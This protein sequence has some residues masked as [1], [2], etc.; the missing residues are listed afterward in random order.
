MW[1]AQATT[2]LPNLPIPWPS[3]GAG[4]LV[5]LAVWLV[6][7]GRLIPRRIHQDTLDEVKFLR[8]TI[9]TMQVVKVELAQQNTK[10]LTEKDLGVH[11]LQSARAETDGAES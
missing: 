7:T 5:T 3:L 2:V 1:L 9:S 11:L 4:A 10:L 6:Y 8:E